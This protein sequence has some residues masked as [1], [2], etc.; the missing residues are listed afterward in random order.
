MAK[1]HARTGVF[2][3]ATLTPEGRVV[4]SVVGL[5]VG[6]IYCGDVTPASGSVKG[7]VIR[8]LPPNNFERN[9][10][11]VIWSVIAGTAAATAE[12]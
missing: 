5:I 1:G 10:P 7:M 8:E 9:P 12:V 3:L 6:A 4:T 2:S 11:L